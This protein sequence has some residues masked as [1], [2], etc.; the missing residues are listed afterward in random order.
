MMTD[1]LHV[2]EKYNYLQKKCG[3]Q[4]GFLSPTI[5]WF[6]SGSELSRCFKGPVEIIEVPLE[7]S[8]FGRMFGVV[9]VV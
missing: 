6:S 3:W 1:T 7:V 4:K 5:I 2:V 9:I 8:G